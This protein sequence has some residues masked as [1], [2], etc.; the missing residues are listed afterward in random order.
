MPPA[1]HDSDAV[2]AIDEAIQ[3]WR[4]GDLALSARFFS[5]VADLNQPLSEVAREAAEQFQHA[6]DATLQ[7]IQSTTDGLMV[8]TQTCDIV[9]SCRDRPYLE[10]APIIHV[11]A[12]T[13]SET[14]RSRRPSL[15]TLPRL[16]KDGLA[17][18]L[19]RT[20]TVEKP[21]AA[22]WQRTPGCDNDEDVRHLAEAL[23][24][25]RARH[26][27]P[28]D[29]VVLTSKLRNRIT[30]K[31]GNQSVEGKALQTLREIRVTA[32]PNWTADS[33]TLFFWFVRE[34]LPEPHHPTDA[35]LLEKWLNL[36]PPQGRFSVV[37]GIVTT[38]DD[39]TAADYVGSDRLDLDYLTTMTTSES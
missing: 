1:A 34:V 29:F 27:F 37:D 20:M 10:V 4:Q 18:D 26:A 32:S 21:V 33:I 2:S 36:L 17:V 8:L 31:H 16:A 28:D 15:V 3:D 38:L 12:N 24:R 39:M 14:E 23:A 22:H 11:D 5:H 19:D 7:V 25:K 13:L 9:R 30:K 35:E 6:T